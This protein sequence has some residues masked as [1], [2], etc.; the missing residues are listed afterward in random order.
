MKLS[1]MT[2]RSCAAALLLLSASVPAH[3]ENGGPWRFDYASDI[4]YM[5]GSMDYDIGGLVNDNGVISKEN[6]PLSKLEFPFDT[7]MLAIRGG[8]TYSDLL[9]TRLEYSRNINNPSSRMKDSDWTDPYNPS[10]KDIYSESS[11]ALN[12]SLL[13]TS[14]RVW[15]LKKRDGNGDVAAALGPGAGYYY[16]NLHWDAGN[17]EQFDPSDPT[18]PHFRFRGLAITYDAR[19]F[20]PYVALYGKVKTARFL[21]EGDLGWCFVTTQ[22]VDDHVL[23]DKISRTH[24]TGH[25][26]KAS[27]SARYF[28]G[29]DFYLLARFGVFNY[30]VKGNQYQDFATG[31]ILTIE[32]KTTSTQLSYSL[33]AGYRF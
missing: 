11:A 9:E 28:A 20:S 18:H 25:G 29:K 6:E 30:T 15:V 23:R 21:L 12:A 17:G 33:G 3:A 22:E 7:L 16:Q 27:L 13:D 1:T 19:I 32:E 8:V 2:R 31:N 26:V 5:A 14:V 10:V 24:G 4:G